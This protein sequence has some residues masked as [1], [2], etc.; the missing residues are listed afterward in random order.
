MMSDKG[1]KTNEVSFGR[2]WD[3]F[4]SERN[5]TWG[6]DVETRLRMALADFGQPPEWFRGKRV[7]DAGC[8]HGILTAQIATLGA[9]VT[10]IDVCDLEQARRRFPSVNYVRGD[11]SNPPFGPEVFDA[12]YSG[13]VLHHTPD[14]RRAFDALTKL[15]RPAGLMYVWLYWRVPGLTYKTRSMIRRTLAPFPYGIRRL[16][17]FPFAAQAALRDRSL[18]FSEHRLAQH[19]FFTPRW[20]FEHTPEEVLGWCRDRGLR[21]ELRS[22]SRDGFGVLVSRS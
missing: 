11:V 12:I 7:L 10:G 20:R 14:T 21:S 22:T 2:Q 17:V 15:L 18:S 3:E 16:P 8:G 19:D 4:D 13:G 6:I 9:N 1:V 5:R